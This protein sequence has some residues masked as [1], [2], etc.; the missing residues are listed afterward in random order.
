MEPHTKPSGIT[1]LRNYFL[2]GFV[3]VAPLTITVYLIWS[4]INW[5]DGWIIPYIP[6]VYNPETYLPFAIPG[7]G[8]VLAILIITMI[9]FL[10]ANFI[11]RAIV[12]YGICARSCSP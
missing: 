2:T 12:N 3:V 1:R 4:F 9:G 7:I 8:L 11:G 5:V 10:T 6:R